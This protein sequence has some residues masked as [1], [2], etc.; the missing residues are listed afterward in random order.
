MISIGSARSCSASSLRPGSI[1]LLGA[2]AVLSIAACGDSAS[3]TAS[4]GNDNGG[5]AA[6]GNGNGAGS[7][8]GGN[9]PT[10]G[11]ASVGGGGGGGSA[12]KGLVPVFLAQGHMGR[13][14]L[15]CDGGDTYVV[16]ESEDDAFRCW[17]GDNTDCDHNAFAGRGLAYGNGVW[18]ATFGWGAPGTLRRSVDGITWQVVEADTPTYADVAFGN[19]NFVTNNSPTRISSDGIT[20][21][22]GGSLDLQINTRAIEFVP[23]GDGV[24]VVTGESGETRDIV[25]SPDGVTWTHALN[26]PPACGQYV[27]NLQYGGGVIAIFSGAGHVCASSDGG[28]SWQLNQVSDN[29]TSGGVWTGSEFYVWA[30]STR[31]K[32]ADGVSW[33]SDAGSPQDLQLDGPVT[34]GADGTFVAVHQSWDNY[35]EDQ[36]FVF[37][38]DGL[39][40]Q[41]AS[42]YVG[43][44]P[45]SFFQFGYVEPSAACPLP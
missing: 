23:H 39:S 16:N 26:R 27:R 22:D 21:T 32:S 33:S 36:R 38:S 6:G 13:T 41:D 43:S 1:A 5:E 12:P 35:Y 31:W 4:G 10:G 14:T 8:D 3:D 2:L 44:H 20:W 11:A 9:T 15:T 19:G 30:G 25:T 17:S 24:F 28:D 40:W 42:D 7:S 34:R 18:I 29:L 37:S 45:M